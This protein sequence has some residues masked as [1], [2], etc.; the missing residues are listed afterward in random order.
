[1][2][3]PWWRRN[4]RKAEVELHVKLSDDLEHIIADKFKLEQVVLNLLSNAKHALDEK[5]ALMRNQSLEYR[6]VIEIETHH[7]GEY[8]YLSVK[9]NGVGIKKKD[10]DKI[11]DPFYTTKRE[12]T[13]T[14]LGLSISYGFIKDI[15][16]EITVDSSEGVHML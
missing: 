11:F 6:K 5:E 2:H 8:V 16:G 7:D 3:C 9:D 1:M 15:L 4:T 12:D 10:I 13:G 14:G